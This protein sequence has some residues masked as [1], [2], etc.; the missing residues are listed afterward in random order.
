MIR[1]RSFG[2][3]IALVAVLALLVLFLQGGAFAQDGDSSTWG[4][5]QPGQVMR[6]PGANA[7]NMDMSGYG[8]MHTGAAGQ[9]AH[10]QM[11]HAETS[12]PMMSMNGMGSHRHMG[13]MMVTG[14]M[15]HN[16]TA[17]GAMHQEDMAG[18]DQCPY[19]SEHVDECVSQ[20]QAA[21]QD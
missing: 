7:S 21:E 2:A 15:V 3:A 1:Q 4:N 10:R 17:A 9:Q 8:Q 12:H 18:A 5:G 20:H 13:S 14:A 11:G 6:G 16:M 19:A